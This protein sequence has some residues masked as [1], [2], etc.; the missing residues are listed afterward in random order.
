MMN[1]FFDVVGCSLRAAEP[2][3]VI[4]DITHIPSQS[5][6]PSPSTLFFPSLQA[7]KAKVRIYGLFYLSFPA[8]VQAVVF[9]QFLGP[10]LIYF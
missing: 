7:E 8:C 3:H 9:F 1:L 10:R 2:L 4:A 5:S 6:N